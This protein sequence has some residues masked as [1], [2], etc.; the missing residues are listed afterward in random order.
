MIVSQ[1]MA[2]LLW[3]GRDAVGQCVRVGADTMPCT[4]VVG[5]VE[6]IKDQSLT[7]DGGLQYYL[8]IDQVRLRG[9]LG[10]DLTIFIRVRGRASDFVET[11]RRA[12]QVE[13]PANAFIVANTMR[14]VVGP[15]E[16]SW[17]SGATLFLLF[18]GLALLLA[19]IGLYSVISFDV[20]QRTH[21]LGVRIALGAQ[22]GDVL[23]LVIGAGMRFGMIGVLAGVVITLL[24]GRFVAPLLF[25]VSPHDPVI[26]GGVGTLVLG[27][28]V[29][30]SGI[31]ALR[32]TR[33]DPS[34]A[35]RAE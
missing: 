19:A 13:M 11:V 17:E 2:R 20:A 31:P 1:A 10:Q 25:D 5:I 30:A 4:T 21:E 7:H 22:V 14:D 33:V 18:S 27:I 28:A 8:P 15:E 12:L 23:Q 35:L 34:V 24:S 29:L 32:A 16:Q 9:S 26:L 6:E 3:P